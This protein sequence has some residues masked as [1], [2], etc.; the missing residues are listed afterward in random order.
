MTLSKELEN[1]RKTKRLC[2]IGKKYLQSL[3]DFLKI[4][5]ILEDFKLFNFLKEVLSWKSQ[6]VQ[7]FTKISFYLY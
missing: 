4:C 5:A 2:G 6:N 7:M 3:L 1:K